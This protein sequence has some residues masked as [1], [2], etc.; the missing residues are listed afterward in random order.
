DREVA[1]LLHRLEGTGDAQ[2]HAL[3]RR[4]EEACRHHRVLLLQCAFHGIE[5]NAQ[6]RQLGVAD[7]D[8][9]LL[10][11]QPDQ[12]DL[13][14]V[15][16]ALQFQLHALGVVLEHGVVEALAGQC[17]DVAEG[18]AEFVVEERA[19]GA[20]R[21]RRADVADLLAHLVPD[22]R[23]V[24]RMQRIARDENH[25]RFA[26]ARVRADELVLAGLHQLLLDALGDF[27]RDLVG[28]RARPQR[29]YHHRLEG[30]GRILGLA[31]VAVRPGADQRQQQHRVDDESAVVQRPLGQ[32][33]TTH[34][35]RSIVW[36]FLLPAQ[37]GEG[38]SERPL[39][40]ERADEG[41]LFLL[42]LRRSPHPGLLPARGEKEELDQRAVRAT[43]FVAAMAMGRFSRSTGAT[44]WPSRSRW[45]PAVTIQ[46]PGFT[47]DSTGAVA[48][49]KAPSC[50]GARRRLLV[51][52]STTQTAVASPA[53]RWIADSGTVSAARVPMSCTY[54]RALWPRST[55]LAASP[56]SSTRVA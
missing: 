51:A 48:S 17:V 32:V 40:E 2:L 20:F 28:G 22:I 1:D 54:T 3:G 53:P 24:L 30:E 29:P 44:T 26:R 50:T 37:R 33:E 21:Q 9:D 39:A 43:G 46:A 38:R 42:R 12:L 4:L 16:Y 47:P 19:D 5:R 15:G 52:G 6:C 11:L 18:V 56:V 7:L 27:T 13:A 10:V 55:A 45:P 34:S 49:P 25:L 14:R 35:Q 31:Q 36:K 41:L 8:P 23:N